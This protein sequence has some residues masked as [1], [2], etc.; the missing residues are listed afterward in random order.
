MSSASQVQ[1]SYVKEDTFGTTPTTPTMKLVPFNTG[2][3]FTNSRDTLQSAQVQSTRQP[4]NMR[5]G[6]NQPAK[7]LTG[8]MQ[9][10][11]FDDLL[12]A[13]FGDVWQGGETI[14]DDVIVTATT[15]ELD[16]GNWSVY[17]PNVAVGNYLVYLDDG[18]WVV[19]YVS[20]VTTNTL[21]LKQADGTT[22]STL[23]AVGTATEK[24]I[25]VGCCGGQL[26]CDATDTLIFS[27]SGS[28]AVLA[29]GHTSDWS[30]L[31]FKAGDN[32]FFDGTSSN[33]G[34]NKITDVS[35]DGNTITLAT[36]PT[37]ETINTLT[38]VDVATDAGL[39]NN[40]NTLDSF[41]FEEAFL[42]HSASY[43]YRQI[44]GVKVGQIGFSIQPNSM[45]TVTFELMGASIVDFTTSVA[46]AETSFTE[47]DSFDSFTGSIEKD[48]SSVSL[49]GINFTLANQLNRNFNLF[50]RNADDMTAGTPQMTG[51][52]N[53]YFDDK[54]MSS[55]YFDETEM[56]V[57][58]RMV[59]PDGNAYALDLQTVKLTNDTISIGDIDVTQ[60]VPYALVPNS[61]ETYE[62]QLRRQ[63]VAH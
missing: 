1:L 37:D 38:T 13:G 61:V 24:T 47:R 23:T 42:D 63:P 60:A 2:D 53:L 14:T 26:S 57:Y 44:K 15:I 39:I 49:T 59:D 43:R 62:A 25:Y 33:E 28:T 9:W 11:N 32:I 31:G 40:G 17:Y 45:I 7:T 22:D 18:S 30:D 19:L 3:A 10:Q 55:A 54:T 58:L 52:M 36:A 51:D 21:T 27:N 35:S 34:W 56:E 5:L 41:T 46:S 6:T 8:E 29:A 48:G 4:R 20:D 12:A 50:S 16:A